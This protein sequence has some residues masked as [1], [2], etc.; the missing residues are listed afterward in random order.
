ME[1]GAS[2]KPDN[3]GEIEQIASMALNT[4]LFY[5]AELFTEDAIAGQFDHARFNNRSGAFVDNLSLPVH[6][7]YRYSAG[8]SADWVRSL[9]H[10]R[11]SDSGTFSILDPF[12]GVGT[13][14]LACK[15][16]GVQSWGFETHPFIHRIASAKLRGIHANFQEVRRIFN[17]FTD[18]LSE[19]PRVEPGHISPLLIKCYS[20]DS[21]AYLLTM[22][23]LFLADFDRKTPESELLW[24]AITAILRVCSGAGTAQWQ[25]VLPNKSKSAVQLPLAAF[26]VKAAEIL[27]DIEYAQRY[28]WHSSGSVLLT[29]ARAPRKCANIQVDAVITSPPYPNNYDYAD[30]TRLEMTFW[31]EINGWGDL[32]DAVRQYLIR[33]CSQHVAAE[34]LLLEDVLREPILEPIQEELSSV[35]HTLAEVRETRG[36]RKS[37]HTMAAA[38]FRDLGLVFQALRSLCRSGSFLCFVIGDS[39]PY[40]VYL[41]VDK[42]LG[43]LA[44]ASGF[45]SYSFEKIRDRN[46]KWKNRKHR[47]PLKEGRLWIQ[48]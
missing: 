48:G 27:Q 17:Q 39:A 24:L 15:A 21:L 45:K 30:A 12:A 23:D 9:I 3:S 7:W 37:Y 46:I 28:S 19:A 33:S 4:S 10:E 20:P 16:E 29:D 41:D 26:Q 44:L 22:R 36:G 40:G 35:C 47:V 34:K 38:Y 14:L 42:W 13:T 1:I 8:F 5:Q 32:Q 2:D 6:R 31:G 43:Q 18:C 11:F 25:Y